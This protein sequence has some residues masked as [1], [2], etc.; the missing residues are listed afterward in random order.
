[1]YFFLDDR[2]GPLTK[3][4]E[5]GAQKAQKNVQLRTQ[6]AKCAQISEKG[7]NALDLSVLGAWIR[8]KR[9]EI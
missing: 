8:H 9:P 3:H 4:A 5:T 2:E 7:T 1:M 6:R